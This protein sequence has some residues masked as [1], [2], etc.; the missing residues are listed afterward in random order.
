MDH[1]SLS[2]L[3]EATRANERAL[4]ALKLVNAPR[5]DARREKLVGYLNLAQAIHDLAYLQRLTGANLEMHQEL[6]RDQ[7]AAHTNSMLIPFEALQTRADTVAGSGFPIGA[8]TVM[9]RLSGDVQPK[10]A[11]LLVAD[12]S[13]SIER[14]GSALRV[15]MPS[16]LDHEVVAFDF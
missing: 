4:D 8:Q 5:P 1:I 15:T 7:M 16:V 9:L 3:R 11:R 10:T 6:S 12:R 2:A 14:T 13:V